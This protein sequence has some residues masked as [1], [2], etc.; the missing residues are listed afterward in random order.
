MSPARVEEMSIPD[1]RF[2]CYKNFVSGH[3][4]VKV[5]NFE[6]ILRSQHN[7]PLNKLT[8]VLRVTGSNLVLQ[9]EKTD[10]KTLLHLDN[11]ETVKLKEST[12]MTLQEVSDVEKPRGSSLGRFFNRMIGGKRNDCKSG[13]SQTI[14]EISL[15]YGFTLKTVN[16]TYTFFT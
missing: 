5:N 12:E 13:F 16:K 6:S 10:H 14:G 11:L 15:Q 1:N 4:K 8:L 2:F 3:V 9:D 7:Y